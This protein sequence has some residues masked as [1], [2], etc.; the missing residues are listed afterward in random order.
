M[1][2]PAL[3][4]PRLRS[5]LAVCAHPDDES[6]GLGAVISAFID[7]G[8]R[9]SVLTFTH[10][11]ASALHGVDGDLRDIRAGELASAGRIL[12]VTISELLAYPDG[13]LDVQPLNQ[14]A[15]HVRRMA[16]HAAADA[17]LVFDLGGI[18]GHRDHRRATEAAVTAAQSLRIRVLAWVFADTVAGRLNTEFGTSF[19]GRATDDVDVVLRVDRGRQ[20]SAIAEHRS[21]STDNPVL[22]RRL[23]LQGD[24]ERLR[25]LV[26]PVAA[27]KLSGPSPTR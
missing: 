13:G 14:L 5:V 19:V 18:T 12:G 15:A 24:E 8:T 10:G 22:L 27:Q 3:M 23:E 25:W 11:E 9:V 7:A 16:G 20:R 21:Q 26:Q 17:L 6:F 1:S 2:A 4:L